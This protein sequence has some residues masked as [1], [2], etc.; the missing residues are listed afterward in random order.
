MSFLSRKQAE[1]ERE[2]ALE[3]PRARWLLSV[4]AL[5]VTGFIAQRLVSNPRKNEPTFIQMSGRP[6]P[7]DPETNGSIPRELALELH[8]VAAPPAGSLAG[9]GR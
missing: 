5:S 2:L 3:A 9:Q 6:E 4:F 1:R 8:E 7:E